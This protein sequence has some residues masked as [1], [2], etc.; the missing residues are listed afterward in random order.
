MWH[1]VTNVL[2]EDQYEGGILFGWPLAYIDQVKINFVPFYD[3]IQQYSGSRSEFEE[4][5]IVK[6]L[7][8]HYVNNHGLYFYS[9][10]DSD[11]GEK[12]NCTKNFSFLLFDHKPNVV[13][14]TCQH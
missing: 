7:T 10:V 9:G 13:L 11:S 1:Q 8:K 12:V 6:S 3:I 4:L 14:L 5:C 2:T